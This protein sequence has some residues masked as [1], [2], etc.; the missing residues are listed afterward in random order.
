MHMK[1]HFPAQHQ[2]SQDSCKAKESSF[3]GKLESLS[4]ADIAALQ[5]NRLSQNKSELERSQ[6]AIRVSCN[7]MSIRL[8]NPLMRSLS[9]IKG[10]ITNFEEGSSR[11][12][13]P[14]ACICENSLA[15]D[16]RVER[17]SIKPE[18]GLSLAVATANELPQQPLQTEARPV[19]IIYIAPV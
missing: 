19:C 18:Q 9:S 10:L 2:V 16:E 13:T 15:A 17:S 12:S 14:R 5:R 4:D 8:I 11:P 1:P 7:L 3:E 6:R